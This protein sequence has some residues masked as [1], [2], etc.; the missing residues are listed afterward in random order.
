[1]RHK[2]QLRV[3]F[4]NARTDYLPYYKNFTLRIGGARPL[5]DLLQLITREHHDFDWPRRN[6]W[7]R[8]DGRVVPCSATIDELVVRRGREWLLE[9][10][11]EYRALH[12]LRI[13]D[14]DFEE[15]FGLIA[16]WADAS[17]R[18]YYRSLYPVHYAS[19]TFRFERG[20]I[21][22]A[23]LITARRILERAP[24]HEEALL[25]RLSAA[26]CGLQCAEYE[27]NLLFPED[28]SAAIEALKRSIH[29]PRRAGL[30]EKLSARLC[31]KAP[32]SFDAESV[33]G[34]RF[35][36]YTG[37]DGEELTEAF[38]ARLREAGASLLPFER[39]DRL[40]GRSLL[41]SAPTFAYRKAGAMLAAAFDSGADALV[42]AHD[43][44]LEMVRSHF[45]A[46]ERAIQRELPLPMIGQAEFD[47]RALR[48]LAEVAAS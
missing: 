14:S 29:H 42:F 35:T 1:M 27:N 31:R 47:R 9:P 4:F 46:I 2:L 11:S 48:P 37:P 32:P 3:F 34:L 12:G 18:A 6:C 38:A 16:P 22:D 23:V 44:D 15:A 45:G 40:I 19:E 26:D 36:Y 7:I 20:Y 17:D 25:E 10:L 43:V 39:S 8:I 13:D 24:E 30:V 33:E 41:E 5:R 21:G 28:H